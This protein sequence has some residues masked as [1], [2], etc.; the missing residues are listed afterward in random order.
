MIQLTSFWAKDVNH[1][2][3]IFPFNS[4]EAPDF[5]P[6]PQ[7]KLEYSTSPPYCKNLDLKS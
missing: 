1:V 2:A 5:I 6:N 3:Y 4:L 7:Q